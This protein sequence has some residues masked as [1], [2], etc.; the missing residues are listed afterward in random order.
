M[1]A[2]EPISILYAGNSGVFDGMV[3][4]LLGLTRHHTGPLR[5]FVMTMDLTDLH[6]DYMP[7]REEQRAYLESLCRAVCDESRVTLLDMGEHYRATML[8]SPNGQTSYTPYCFLR[9]YADRVPELPDRLI[10]LDTDT[11]P[12][13]DLRELWEVEL[14]GEELAGVRDFYGH[15][16]FG[17]RYLNSGVLL[18]D[19]VRIRETGLFRRAIKACA[20]EKIFL[21]DQTA[22][23]RFSVRKRILSRRFN[24][25]KRRRSDTLIRHF[26]MN[27][28]WFPYF[29]T[30]NIKPWQVE[31]VRTVLK[32]RSYDDVLDD[33]FRRRAEKPEFFSV[34]R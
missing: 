25:Q 15:R 19:L 17:V 21:P 4:S 22:I 29:R 13:G 9:L 12:V 30:R 28:L 32:D 34:G 20:T 31:S 24:E 3:I 23:N 18:L 14:S 2:D 8:D 7:I 6:P 16:F 27:I 26:S 10:Y 5:V 1:Q 33:Y 11:L